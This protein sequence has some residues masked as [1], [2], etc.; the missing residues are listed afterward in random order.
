MEQKVLMVTIGSNNKTEDECLPYAT[1]GSVANRLQYGPEAK[2]LLK[3]RREVLAPILNESLHRDGKPLHES[4]YNTGLVEGPDFGGKAQAGCY[5]PA[6]LRFDG[7]FYRALGN[8]QR[9]SLAKQQS[10]GELLIVSTLYGLLTAAEPIQRYN[11]DIDEVDTL[12][13]PWTKDGLLTEVLC[14][15]IKYQRITCVLD[16]TA[17]TRFRQLID[18]NRVRRAVDKLL[19][20]H[21]RQIAG[22][23]SLLALGDLARKLLSEWSPEELESLH[24]GQELH[25]P[26]EVVVFSTEAESPAGWATE[27]DRRQLTHGQQLNEWRKAIRKMLQHRFPKYFVEGMSLFQLLQ[28]IPR[29]IEM[30]D[31]VR[32]S[33]TRIRQDRNDAECR[34]QDPDDREWERVTEAYDLVTNWYKGHGRPRP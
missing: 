14:A 6:V 34:D 33:I 19:H 7:R 26:S 22:D 16:L 11:L 25:L 1:D 9:L 13:Q 23:A 4:L 5:L 31:S 3:R 27:V 21:G 15:Y 17:T 8:A 12:G 29:G 24:A 32:R 20:C 2:S 18:W 28:K 10:R 30:P